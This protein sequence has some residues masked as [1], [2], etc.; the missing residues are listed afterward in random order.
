VSYEFSPSWTTRSPG[1]FRSTIGAV[2]CGHT[3]PPAVTT[4]GP[5]AYYASKHSLRIIAKCLHRDTGSRYPVMVSR[6]TRAMRIRVESVQRQIDGSD[7]RENCGKK[8]DRDETAAE[9][10][11]KISSTDYN[12]PPTA[13]MPYCCN[14]RDIYENIIIILLCCC[15]N[16]MT[17]ITPMDIDIIISRTDGHSDGTCGG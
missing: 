15:Y 2:L 13:V 17:T 11:T 7:V 12:Q 6:V 5:A 14:A 9:T 16:N 8:F 4:D 10:E 3:R 1:H